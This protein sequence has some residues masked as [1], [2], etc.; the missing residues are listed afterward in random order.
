V[1]KNEQRRLTVAYVL[2]YW[3]ISILEAPELIFA[4]SAAPIQLWR[5]QKWLKFFINLLLLQ[6]LDVYCK[7][8][9]KSFLKWCWIISL[10]NYKRRKSVN[11]RF[12]MV[13]GVCVKS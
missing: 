10:V 4:E 5:A 11:W 8:E 7:V 2:N 3:I 9:I 1:S 13:E 6:K 12:V